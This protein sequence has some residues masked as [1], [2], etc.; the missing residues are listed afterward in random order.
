MTAMTAKDSLNPSVWDFSPSEPLSLV[1]ICLDSVT[2]ESLRL[3]AESASIRIQ[4]HLGNYRVEDYN[5][6]FEWIGDP[7]PN[8]CLVDFDQDRRGA[9]MVAERIHSESP[10]TAVFAVSSQSQPDAIIEAMRSGCS[11]YLVKPIEQ[12]QLLN[13][14]ARIGGRKKERKEHHNARVLTFM[15]SKGGS[16]V[17]T[18][19]TQLGALLAS[20]Y[21]RKTLVVDL[22]PD[23]GDAALYLGLTKYGYHFFELLESNDR[24]DAE[25][26]Q[27]F[28]VHHA[29]GVDVIPAPA[30]IEPAR[31]VTP[32]SVG[33][34]VDFLR[35][36]YEFILVDVPP[37][38]N[39]ESLELI[40]QCDQLYIV[41]VAEISAL[42]NVV[43]QV[44][45]L[46]RKRIPQE[47]IRIVLNR[48]QKH[49][50][51]SDEQIEKVVQQKIFWKV[52]N[53]YVEV[54]K[55]ISGGNPA[56]NFSSSEVTRSLA[57]WA[58]AVGR[59]PTPAD[60]QKDKKK[61]SR[62]LLGLWGR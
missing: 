4:K 40:R 62:G 57:G 43:R 9:A 16:G 41:T 39:D 5:S 3:F 25:L 13:A 53:H 24:L 8:V 56:G 49:G 10:E 6:V 42:R 58:E 36:R 35:L 60:E 23:F 59:K 31:H 18:L 12:E 51:I 14:A 19:V 33:R 38:L 27:S 34:T 17:T 52:P 7:P 20:A 15:G 32:G 50:L 29:S 44:E 26:L 30:E 46:T 54:L 22:H 48:H 61:Q 55:A 37:G 21:S 1:G 47:K 11:E 2:L 28:V 45:C